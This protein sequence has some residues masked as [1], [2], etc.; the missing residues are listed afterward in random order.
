MMYLEK[1]EPGIYIRRRPS[2]GLRIP[3]PTVEEYSVQQLIVVQKNSLRSILG[4]LRRAHGILFKHTFK[5]IH[6]C[7]HYF[8]LGQDLNQSHIARYLA[9]D[10]AQFP[11]SRLSMALN[12]ELAAV[13]FF[14]ILTGRLYLGDM[15]GIQLFFATTTQ[16]SSEKLSVSYTMR[17]VS[18]T[19]PGYQSNFCQD[20]ES[21]PL[22]H[23]KPVGTIKIAPDCVLQNMKILVCPR[24]RF[25]S[26]TEV[27][28]SSETYYL[29]IRARSLII[30][31]RLFLQVELGDIRLFPMAPPRTAYEMAE[32]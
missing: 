1:L 20:L 24:F 28:T 13:S 21:E 22:D 4:K 18:A 23:E 6:I 10:I 32:Y 19:S 17:T 31:N 15:T 26:G 30:N 16:D 3:V 9:N 12:S 27:S 14:Y 8:A 5:D 29:P 25:H 7:N 2:E 11:P